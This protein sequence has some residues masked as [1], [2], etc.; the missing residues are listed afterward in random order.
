MKMSMENETIETKIQKIKDFLPNIEIIPA[1]LSAK[2]SEVKSLLK[3]FIGKFKKIDIDINDNSIIDGI[4]TIDSEDFIQIL[5]ET[6]LE[7]DIKILPLFSLHLMVGDHKKFLPPHVLKKINEICLQ[8]ES[9]NFYD[10]DLPIALQKYRAT[11]K[12]IVMSLSISPAH[13]KEF[14]YIMTHDTNRIKLFDKLQIMTVIPGKQGGN[15][16][17]KSLLIIPKIKSFL[18][19]LKIKIDGGVNSKMLLDIST[20]SLEYLNLIDEASVGSYL[21]R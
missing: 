18:P 11:N 12:K 6:A 13:H 14:E 10:D 7:E 16:L 3:H 19:E 21:C 15:F 2:H 9:I 4:K 1:I 20:E 8:Y 5:H 17:E